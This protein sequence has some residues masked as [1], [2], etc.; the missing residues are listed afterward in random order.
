ELEKLV[1]EVIEDLKETLLTKREKAF[2]I[3]M[4]EVMK[5]VRGRIDGKIV[6]ETVK[7]RLR[8]ALGI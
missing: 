2:N 8:E 3:V 7:N 5:K 4:G 6:A 1:D